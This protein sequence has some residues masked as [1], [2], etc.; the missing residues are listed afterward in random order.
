MNRHTH[1]AKHAARALKKQNNDYDKQVRK[2]FR[3][4]FFLADIV[5]GYNYEVKKQGKKW[6]LI[7]QNVGLEKGCTQNL[8]D[9]VM[10]GIGWND[11]PDKMLNFV[12]FNRKNVEIL[13]DFLW[14]MV[15]FPLSF[16]YK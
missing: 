6:T 11:I 7:K 15:L 14:T 10:F 16:V 13:L 1:L 9:F 3:S 4:C 2:R 12:V 8:W 5:I